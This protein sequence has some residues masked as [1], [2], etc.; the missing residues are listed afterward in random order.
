MEL[1]DERNFGADL[2]IKMGFVRLPRM[3]LKM[4]LVDISPPEVLV[5]KITVK[6]MLWM[7]WLNQ[8]AIFTLRTFG[9]N[10]TK[11]VC[12]IVAEEMAT[13]LRMG[14]LW[15][16]KRFARALLKGVEDRLRQWV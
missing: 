10:K 12:Q 7:I 5:I 2:P 6:R 3:H 16:V 8:T 13:L 15:K 11:V 4:E 14:F 9:E 1:Y